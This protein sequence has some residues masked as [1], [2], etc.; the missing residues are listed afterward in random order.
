MSI[1][2]AIK[3]EIDPTPM[4]KLLNKLRI[5]LLSRPPSP[6]THSAPHVKKGT[7]NG[8]GGIQKTVLPPPPPRE[9]LFASLFVALYFFLSF[10]GCP[11]S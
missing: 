9:Y 11:C 5:E 7:G 10:C 6:Q 4:E 3:G 1:S 2:T 8:G